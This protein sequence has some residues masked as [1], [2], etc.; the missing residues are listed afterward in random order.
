MSH[1]RISKT[2]GL[3]RALPGR[4]FFGNFGFGGFGFGG[5]EEEQTPKGHT[6][7]LDLEVTLKDLYLGEHLQASLRPHKTGA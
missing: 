1:P 4:R 5:Q 2:Y 3:M 7:K 6:V